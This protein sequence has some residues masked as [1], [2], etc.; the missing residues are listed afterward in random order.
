MSD[1]IKKRNVPSNP[2]RDIPVQKMFVTPKTV[3]LFGQQTIQL[4][5]IVSPLKAKKNIKWSHENYNIAQDDSTGA[6]KGINPGRTTI[7]ATDIE[8]GITAHAT[9]NVSF[10]KFRVAVKDFVKGN[11][12]ADVPDIFRPYADNRRCLAGKD[13]FDLYLF[14]DDGS[15]TQMKSYPPEL[16]GVRIEDP[17]ILEVKIDTVQEGNYPVL[18]FNCLGNGTTKVSIYFEDQKKEVGR[19]KIV[20]WQIFNVEINEWTGIHFSEKDLVLFPNITQ[21]LKTSLVPEDAVN[22][23]LTWSSSDPSTVV[24]T[25]NGMVT[26]LKMGKAVITATTQDGA[27]SGSIEANVCK[28]LLCDRKGRW[29][30]TDSIKPLD[31]RWKVYDNILYLDIYLAFIDGDSFFN[32]PSEDVLYEIEDPEVLSVSVSNLYY[33]ENYRPSP[34]YEGGGAIITLK[35]LKK[36]HSKL[37]IMLRRRFERKIIIYDNSFDV[38]IE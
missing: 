22:K 31:G 6:E 1:H 15:S 8:T 23:R 25:Q 16:I 28:I 11:G 36:G 9:V 2:L 7:T 24:V 27:L 4:K 21:R 13:R 14:S 33:K 26:G 3:N 30:H 20:E 5:A 17:N 18:R 35:W 10:P 32:I 12:F 29:I 19:V 34:T 37:R 38:I